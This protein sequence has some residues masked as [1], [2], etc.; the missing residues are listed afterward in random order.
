[1][2]VSV[3]VA[4]IMKLTAE[5]RNS[6]TWFFRNRAIETSPLAVFDYNVAGDIE[7][8]CH[9]CIYGSIGAF[10]NILDALVT[11]FAVPDKWARRHGAFGCLFGLLWFPFKM[12]S[13][14]LYACLY[15]LDALLVGCN[16]QCATKKKEWILN[17]FEKDEAAIRVRPLTH[18]EETRK[19]TYEKGLDSNEFSLLL[20]AFEFVKDAREVFN[21]CSP[22]RSDMIHCDEVKLTKLVNGLDSITKFESNNERETAKEA[23]Q[24]SGLKM[25]TFTRFCRIMHGVVGLRLHRRTVHRNRSSVSRHGGLGDH[26][27]EN[28]IST[29]LLEVKVGA[30]GLQKNPKVNEFIKKSTRNI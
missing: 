3:E 28:P 4:V 23:L 29:P 2:K 5:S 8:C 10:M 25:I 11:V 14:V 1:L 24:L 21:K 9:G 15:L 19:R 12:V 13:L 7:N 6:I 16:N 27:E 30:D 18:V 20:N 26:D 17:P 22:V